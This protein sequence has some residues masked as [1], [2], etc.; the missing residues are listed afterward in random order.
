M[1]LFAR[2]VFA[3]IYAG[4]ARYPRHVMRD[5]GVHRM[6]ESDAAERKKR[7]STR[8]ADLHQCAVAIY[9]QRTTAIALQQ[10]N[11]SSIQRSAMH[12]TARNVF[13]FATLTRGGVPPEALYAVEFK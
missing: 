3:E 9:R 7:E 4:N 12:S 10:Q 13:F 11:Y 8:N 2:I 1:Y 6:I 5:S